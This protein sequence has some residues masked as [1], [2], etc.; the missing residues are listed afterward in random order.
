MKLVPLL[1]HQFNKVLFVGSVSGVGVGVVFG[2][3]AL[4]HA[5]S[6][7]ILGGVLCVYVFSRIFS[8]FGGGGGGVC[9]C[10]V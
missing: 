6:L 10:V 4:E 9:V 5:N 7:Y 1:T 3:L 2:I 8:V